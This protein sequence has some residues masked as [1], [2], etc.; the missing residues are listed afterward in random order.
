[1]SRELLEILILAA[2]AGVVVARLYAVLG[3]RTGAE[4]PAHSRTATVEAGASVGPAPPI[5]QPA[6]SPAVTGPAA[7][8]MRADPTFDPVHFVA[9]AKSAYE[10]IVQSFAAGDRDSLRPLLS[11][12]VF[13]SY[14]KAIADRETSGG[15]G[16]E[17]VRLKSADIV[18]S[19]V[20]GDIV[21][22]AVRFEAELAEGAAG[23][24]ETRERWTFERDSRSRDPNWLLSAV[25]QA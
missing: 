19:S 8:A 15:Q 22:V 25:S 18:D 13:A 21:R 1:L 6:S 3:R 10:I 17:L 9:G 23:I 2:I 12:R 20:S 5:P 24:R 7:E 11:P 4:P 16:P 14:E